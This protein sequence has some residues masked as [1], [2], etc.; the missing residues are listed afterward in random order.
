MGTTALLLLIFAPLAGATVED[1]VTALEPGPGAAGEVHEW[2]SKDGTSFRYRIPQGFDFEKGANLTFILHGSNLDRRWGFWN[3]DHKKFRPDDVVISPDGT[4]PNG[5][6]GFNFLGESA[7]AKKFQAFH[8]EM[9]QVFKARE[10]Y[11]YGH[12]QGSFFALYY[13]G[14]HPENVDGVV[15]HAS[16]VWTWTALGKKGHHQAIVFMHGTRDPVVPYG[17]SV[18][19]YEALVDAKYPLVRLRGLE[20]WNH[21]PAEENGPVRHTSQQLAWCEGMRSTDPARLEA[22]LKLLADNSGGK[23]RHDYAALHA[24]AQRVRSMEKLPAPLARLAT[25][26]IRAVEALAEAHVAEMKL[27][28]KPAFESRAWVGHLPLFL[29]DFAG[30][31]AREELARKWEKDLEKQDKEATAQLRK[32]WAAV[33]RRDDAEAFEAGV[34]AVTGGFLHHACTDPDLL[35]NLAG[36][37]KDAQRLKLQKKVVKAYD[38]S[39]EPLAKLLEAGLRDFDA[40][41][42]KNGKL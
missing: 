36:W 42:R 31:R 2:R 3:H 22:C 32:Y 15:A 39:V 34:A 29:R 28:A 23:E 12:S 37:R 38:E 17:Q 27:P 11:L 26:A 13:A 20:G 8:Q 7:D 35:E 1:D 19:G 25:D 14:L 21:W 24:V 6:G 41:N 4:T 33:Q 40:V 30:V 5:N 18:G 9:K 16:G 10:T